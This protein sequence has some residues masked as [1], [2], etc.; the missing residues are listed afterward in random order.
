ME[1]KGTLTNH[2]IGRYGRFANGMFQIMGLIGIAKE[3]GFDWAVPRW[4][5]W[6]HKER[7]NSTEDVDVYKH[8][9]HDMP[10]VENVNWPE[11]HYGWGYHCIQLPTGNQTITGHFQSPKYFENAMP[12]IRHFL[13]FKDEP[14]PSNQVAIHVRRG[15]YDNAYHP[16]L[17]MS[18]YSQAMALF[19]LGTEF[20]LFSDDLPAAQVMFADAAT[21][22]NI[23]LHPGRDYLHDFKKMK[24]CHS[25]IIG[26]SSYSA[27]A[28][29]LADQPGKR[30]IAPRSW[31]GP[32]WGSDH[33][34]M[35]KD[36][37][38]HTWEVI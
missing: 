28:A 35:S 37:Y 10:I 1:M 34:N 13:K 22:H 18:Y 15:D 4:I 33:V 5:N 2:T 8:L 7:F 36:I 11:R 9:A 12:E 30:V 27:A 25:F 26:N 21:F 17:D 32:A 38:H 29:I 24:N 19:P 14:V 31:F 20:L 3:Q 16:L 6:D 23:T